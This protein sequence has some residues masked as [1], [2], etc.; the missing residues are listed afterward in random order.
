MDFNPSIININGW[1]DYGWTMDM[2]DIHTMVIIIGSSSTDTHRFIP[3]K[4]S[5]DSLEARSAP[6]AA[7]A[8]TK[9]ATRRPCVHGWWLKLW[10]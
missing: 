8:T 5:P 2:I 3:I 1:M 7:G 10:L 4:P 6:R 9:R